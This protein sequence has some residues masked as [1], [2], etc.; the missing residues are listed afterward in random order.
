MR[1]L[2]IDPG[3]DTTGYGIVE[4]KG[5]GFLL[6]EAGVIKTSPRDPIQE[7]VK[8]IYR[9]VNALI[10]QFKP[11]TLVLEKIYTH[12]KH[13]TTV[14]L[15]GH[16]RGVVC[17]ASGEKNIPLI[18]YPAKRI[19]KA[20]TGN[21]NA[22]KEQVQRMVQTILGLKESKVPVDVTD[23]LAAAIAHSYITLNSNMT[24]GSKIS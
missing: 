2:G 3:L 22:S 8:K 15:M 19:K 5:G 1:I 24:L 21:G 18:N 6:L 20:V 10:N 4:N 16:S 23:A 11:Q 12:Y 17:L 7:R 9:G 13:P 14:I